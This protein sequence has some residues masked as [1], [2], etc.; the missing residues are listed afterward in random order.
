VFECVNVSNGSLLIAKI[1]K[2]ADE[3]KISQEIKILEALNDTDEVI[4]FYGYDV[5]EESG[6]IALYFEHLGK[7]CQSLH[8]NHPSLTGMQLHLHQIYA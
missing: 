7:D 4:S 5:H 6:T 1:L 8:D 3:E 2:H